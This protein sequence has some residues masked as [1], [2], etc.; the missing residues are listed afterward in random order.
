MGWIAVSPLK[1]IAA[2]SSLLSLLDLHKDLSVV[3]DAHPSCLFRD[4]NG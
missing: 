1:D 3:K 2:L 4:D